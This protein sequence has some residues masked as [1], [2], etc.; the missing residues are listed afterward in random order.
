[1]GGLHGARP[2]QPLAPQGQRGPAPR[3]HVRAGGNARGEILR[4]ERP[5]LLAVTWRYGDL[6]DSQVELR[7]SA[8]SDEGTTLELEHFLLPDDGVVGVGIGWELPLSI[9]LPLYLRGE[10]PETPVGEWYEPGEEQQRLAG[11][12]AGA[13][14]SLAQAEGLPLPP[15]PP[16]WA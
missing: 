15:L 16:D 12:A 3:R 10:L 6:P 4:C 7:L 2:A 11:V 9:A 5:H 1:M 13:W 8:G 14:M